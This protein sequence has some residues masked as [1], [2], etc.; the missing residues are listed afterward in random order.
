VALF[1]NAN[2]HNAAFFETLQTYPVA[3][4]SLHL[5]IP[6]DMD[7][8]CRCLNEQT[9]VIPRAFRDLLV[10]QLWFDGQAESLTLISDRFVVALAAMSESQVEKAT[11]DWVATFHYEESA[12]QTPTYKA[13]RRLYE[14]A[15]DTT[16]QKKALILRLVG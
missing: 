6:D 14:L 2:E 12:E 8:L 7:S 3:D 1:A 10:E 11:L 16:A 5:S 4:F 13:V 9:Q 15:R